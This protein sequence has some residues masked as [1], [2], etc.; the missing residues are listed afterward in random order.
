[1]AS[2]DEF[3][4]P[5]LN[6]HRT[7]NFRT[8]YTPA[9]AILT[10]MTGVTMTSAQSV[11]K[12][13]GVYQYVVRSAN[14]SVAEATTAIRH[15]AAEAGW[16]VTSIVEPGSP[17]SCDFGSRVLILRDTEYARIVMRAN[18]L[19]GPFAVLDRVNVFEDEEGVHVSVVNP[20]NINR[21]VLMNDTGYQ[22]FFRKQA[23]RLREVII[24]TVDGTP[25][26][27]QY[28]QFRDEGHIG[29]TM[30]V[31]AG[32]RFDGK[33]EELAFLTDQPWQAVAS[34]VESGLREEGPKWGTT[35]SYRV[36]LPEFETIVFG[37]TG[38]PL[39]SK[40]FEIVGAGSDESRKDLA[41]P[42]IAHAAAYPI[43]IVVAATEDGTA[44]RMVDAMFR[45][46]MYFEDAGKWAFMKNMTMPGSIA[47]ELKAKIVRDGTQ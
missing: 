43:E 16:I 19:T 33:V 42:G 6:R 34:S 46:K 45:M 3:E 10:L 17:A 12:N 22:D 7:M 26:S 44:I 35:L 47:D 31:M 41:C 4:K 2:F 9:L 38:T 27:K 21:T 24:A 28:G 8:R 23:D 15:G 14:V 11:Q 5:D 18:Q 32:G 20:L 1:M 13:H 25:S 29:K 39:D 40:S 36:D 30:G 37:T